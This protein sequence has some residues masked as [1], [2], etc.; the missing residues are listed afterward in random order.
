MVASASI[1]F[2]VSLT[3][4]ALGAGWSAT[5]GATGAGV[6]AVGGTGSGFGSC[7]AGLGLGGGVSPVRLSKKAS[8]SCTSSKKPAPSSTGNALGSAA[9]VSVCGGVAGGSVAFSTAAGSASGP[10]AAGSDWSLG[11]GSSKS[12]CANSCRRA[13]SSNSTRRKLHT[14]RSTSSCAPP[15]F[16]WQN[17]RIAGLSPL[18]RAVSNSEEAATSAESVTRDVCSFT[19]PGR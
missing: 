8:S 3:G 6:S 19:S 2:S 5:L 15:I 9:A 7:S 13:S 16:L 18:A 1:S 4:L 11:W 12:R 10:L 14:S 17:S